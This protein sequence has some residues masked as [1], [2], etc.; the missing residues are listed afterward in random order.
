MLGLKKKGGLVLVTKS[1]VSRPQSG[2]ITTVRDVRLSAI[3]SSIPCFWFVVG[4]SNVTS[5][6]GFLKGLSFILNI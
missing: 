4:T 6:A 3:N 1:L 5:L 2:P